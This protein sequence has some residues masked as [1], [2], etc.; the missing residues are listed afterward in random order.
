M[1]TTKRKICCPKC[2][3][4]KVRIEV[5][6]TAL[7]DLADGDPN[8]HGSQLE[9]LTI[10]NPPKD[11]SRVEIDDSWSTWECRECG[12]YGFPKTFYQE[13]TNG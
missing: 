1:S 5:K 11:M 4:T 2:G 12:N 9:N 6:F 13:V 10:E 8:G 3:G 7:V